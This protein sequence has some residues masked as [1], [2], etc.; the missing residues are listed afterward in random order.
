[1]PAARY[2]EIDGEL[3]ARDNG[4]WRPAS[5]QEQQQMAAGPLA[6]AGQ[7]FGNAAVGAA[8]FALRGLSGSPEYG[9]GDTA[10]DPLAASQQAQMQQ[11]AAMYP[12]AS[13]IGAG[14]YL[15]AETAATGGLAGMGGLVRA[16]G[17]KVGT[18]AE[19]VAE[20]IPTAA[21]RQAMAARR[22]GRVLQAEAG[23]N[24]VGAAET[25]LKNQAMNVINEPSA[26]TDQQ[27]AVQAQLQ[28]G[29]IDFE[30]IPGQLVGGR[31][32]LSGITSH[33]PS[34]AEF[35]PEMAANYTTGTNLFKRG[36]GLPDDTQ[37]TMDILSKGEQT[38]GAK[39]DAVR[40]AVTEPIQL[41]EAAQEVAT[42]A[43][44]AYSRRAMDLTKPLPGGEALEVR[45]KLGEL[46]RT[47]GQNGDYAALQGTLKA[48]DEID[49]A[50][51]R[52]LTPAQ[53]AVQ[54]EAKANWRVKLL[55][56]TGQV[57]GKDGK[58]NLRTAY[59]AADK[60][61]GKRFRG[62]GPQAGLSAEESKLLDWIKAANAF[63]EAVGNSGTAERLLSVRSMM[64]P[65]Q[66]TK[67]IIVA[68]GT[69]A[70]ADLDMQRVNPAGYLKAQAAEQAAR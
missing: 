14:A 12:M 45:S 20:A 42:P 53:L 26:L 66:A 61:Y 25:S 39:F 32:T 69:R 27:R 23:P 62:F 11:R 8:Q 63:P 47:Q 10:L 28:S 24:S 65:V 37:F 48:I 34:L 41:S 29:A 30:T 17:R 16:G 59:N 60:I 35:S 64:N 21:N 51:A 38:A 46:S 40:D 22:A 6:T 70:R 44:D 50:V 19:R 55:L 18:M 33:A 54:Q 13:D 57:F 68:K 1:M 36:M 43:L 3:W 5:D 52:Q 58:I 2:K 67:D 4:Q 15:A 7:A 31:Q 9:G 56:D 49:E